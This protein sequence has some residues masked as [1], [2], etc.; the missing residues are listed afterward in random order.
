MECGDLDKL[1]EHYLTKVR[2]QGIEAV[3][4]PSE[5]LLMSSRIYH[6]ICLKFR[7]TFKP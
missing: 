5:I 1:P 7:V 6:T 3:A 4:S 2:E